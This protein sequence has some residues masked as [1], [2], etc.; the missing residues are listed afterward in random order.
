MTQLYSNLF[1][2][3]RKKVKNNRQQNV[4]M[5]WW[6]FPAETTRGTCLQTRSG[7]PHICPFFRRHAM[8]AVCLPV[9]QH[10]EL[11]KESALQRMR[12][13]K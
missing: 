11:Q 9:H 4:N 7:S 1:V 12:M 5:M 10:Q 13:C 6:F 2:T 3:S 8:H